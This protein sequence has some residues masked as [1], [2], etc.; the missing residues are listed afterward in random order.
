MC[1]GIDRMKEWKWARKRQWHPGRSGGYSGY[2]GAAVAEIRMFPSNWLNLIGDC[3][4]G[5]TGENEVSGI[6]LNF[7]M[8]VLVTKIWNSDGKESLWVVEIQVRFHL[9]CLHKTSD[10]YYP[11]SEW[12]P[13]AGRG[14]RVIGRKQGR[15]A[16][17][18]FWKYHKYCLLCEILQ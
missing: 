16:V 17:M 6:S 3:M 18:C 8:Q 2:V 14:V 12:W 9:K 11:G 7:R 10:I 5:Q 1:W 13:G 4:P 15:D